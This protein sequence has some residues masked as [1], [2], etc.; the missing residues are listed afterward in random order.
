MKYSFKNITFAVIGL[1]FVGISFAAPPNI[2]FNLEEI[3]QS[4]SMTGTIQLMLVVFSISFVPI[5]LM[6]TTSF[7]R[8]V[9]VLS[10][11]KNAVGTQ[12][13]PPA[14][15]IVSLAMFMTIFIMSPVWQNVYDNAIEPYNKGEITYSKMWQKGQQPIREFMLKQTRERELSLFIDFSKIGEVEKPEDIPLYVIIPAFALSELKTAFQMAF[16]IFVPFLVID[17]IVAN[18][19]LSLGMFMLSP[20]MVSL[21]FKILLFVLADG[22]YLISSGLLSSFGTA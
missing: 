6:T 14:P 7:L 16:V 1:L 3:V 4:A 20:V 22:W 10:M 13:V 12:Q 15:V 11:I 9:I 17:L 5:L 18:I 19:L 21:P 8:V 2:N